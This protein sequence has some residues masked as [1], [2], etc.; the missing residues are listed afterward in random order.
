MRRRPTGLPLLASR[1]S[2]RHLLPGFN[3]CCKTALPDA[4]LIGYMQIFSLFGVG[5]EVDTLELLLKNPPQQPGMFPDPIYHFLFPHW[6]E[7]HSSSL[8]CS[9]E[10]KWLG[11][12]VQL[13]RLDSVAKALTGRPIK[14]SWTT[15]R[16]VTALCNTTTT[17]ILG[18]E[19]SA[20]RKLV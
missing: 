12:R 11:E 15:S 6:A 20:S 4:W 1:S 14:T 17:T 9:H 7:A 2:N 5:V 16:S 10:S 13:S 18:L 19:S 3:M 8:Q